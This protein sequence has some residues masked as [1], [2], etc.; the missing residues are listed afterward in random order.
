[1]V[2]CKCNKSGSCSGCACVKAG[3]SCVNCLPSKLGNCVN[4]SPTGPGIPCV[5]V[6]MPVPTP[7]PL[8]TNTALPNS[9]TAFTSS[10]LTS[11][12][13][14]ESADFPPL[15]SAIPINAQLDSATQVPID[16][17]QTHL[18]LPVQ[19]PLNFRWGEHTGQAIFDVVNSCY[20]EVVH[21]K[22]NL[23][24]VP[25]GSAGTSF[26]K[27]V[28]RLLQ[29][30][31]DGSSL[32]RISMKAISLMQILL[33]QTPSKRSKTK[34]H[35][36]HLKRRLDLWHN[37]DLKLLL[38][39][40]QCIQN[41]MISR[42]FPAKNN[43]DGY[44]FRSLMAQ[45]KV[46]SAL[47]YISRDQNSGVLDLDDI[48]P[49]TN[50][51]TTRDVLRAKHPMGIPACPESLLENTP[52]VVNPIIYSSLD[53]DCVLG[54]A[55]HTHGAAGISVLD[56]LAWRRLCSSFKSGS[57]DLFHALAAVGRRIC[58]SRIHSD[59]LSAFVACQLIPL[60]KCPGVRPIRVGEVPRRIISKAILSLFRQDI[61]E[62]A[63]PLQVCA[64][65]EGGCEAAVHAMRQFFAENDVEGALLVDA[66]NAFN[67]INR[68]AAL[69]NVSSICPPLS[70]ILVNTYQ[71][72]IRCIISGDG[73][74]V[75]SEGTTQGDP[76]AMAMYALAV[77]PLISKLK[78]DV[79]NVKQVWYADDATGAGTCDDLKT[80][81]DCFQLHGA[82]YGY[83]PNAIK[84]HLVVKAEHAVKA[85]ELFEGSGV[86][87]TTDGKRHLGAAIGSK[88]FTEEYVMGMVSKWCDEIK[89]LANIAQVQPHAAY[90]AYTHGLSSRWTF[91]TRTIPGIAHLLQPLEDAIHQHLIPALTGRPPCSREERDLLALPVRL[92][93]LGISNP[94]STSIRV[95]E[96]S[97]RL[98][99]P[100]SL[101]LPPKI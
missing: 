16:T 36:S 34:E 15:P 28:A 31:E 65:Q 73:E 11:V 68:Q 44:I 21:W 55:L 79:P 93:G 56:A 101:Q 86:N 74:I 48:I 82:S 19:Q 100:W 33:L 1:M 13:T 85:R 63:G 96:A 71:A 42:K 7:M 66:S 72:P 43:V 94:A 64:G 80:F 78:S 54:A 6:P 57:R 95:F 92:G 24:L 47:S 18:L 30:F 17:G 29:A 61:Q 84:T 4:V 81:W 14:T 39:E 20:E 77:K 41:R 69:H 60:N 50:S 89:Q 26:V 3:K 10:I 25:F 35:I 97:L 62:A 38:E 49:Q 58:S 9:T 91:L 59:N 75:S 88:S 53:A 52:E 98:T 90:S 23:F 76:L 32:E 8:S 45:G 99:S 2:C 27:E 67:T 5:P 46:K 70:Q 87:V 12:S 51:L 22:P 83:H 40:G 37:G